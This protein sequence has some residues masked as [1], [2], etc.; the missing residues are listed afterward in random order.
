M[1]H[2]I[3]IFY[4]IVYK[5]METLITMKVDLLTILCLS[6]TLLIAEEV[7]CLVV[8]VSVSH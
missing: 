5:D 3:Y 2:Y 7:Q 8:G 4:D 6:I 1:L